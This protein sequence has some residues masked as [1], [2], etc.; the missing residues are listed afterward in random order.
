MDFGFTEE[1]RM[2]QEMATPSEASRSLPNTMEGSLL[3]GTSTNSYLSAPAGKFSHV[4]VVVSPANKLKFP[5]SPEIE[6]KTR[7]EGWVTV[8]GV[9]VSVCVCMVA[10]FDV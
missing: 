5:A 6:E 8:G 3:S 9:G 10:G 7:E 1:Q 4:K 2:V